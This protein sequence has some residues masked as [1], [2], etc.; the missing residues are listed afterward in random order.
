MAVF[1]MG[2]INFVQ[3]RSVRFVSHSDQWSAHRAEEKEVEVEII[4]FIPQEDLDHIIDI[5]KNDEFD[6]MDYL[7][8]GSYGTVYGYKDYAI[9]KIYDTDPHGS[10][11]AKVLK[12]ISHLDSIPTLYAIIDEHTLV[13]ERI[14]GKT[15]KDYS[16]DLKNP[17]KIKKDIINQ[18]E[19]ILISILKLGYSP[20][21]LHESNVMI[22]E[23]TGTL[24]V[25]D[26]GF[27]KKHGND[28]ANTYKS[29][30]GY[31]NAQ[32]WAGRVLRDYVDYAEMPM[33]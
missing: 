19:D 28:D 12:D 10:S 20:H 24:K 4:N 1:Q 18:W 16:Y 15:V 8:S 17:W 13:V 30:R 23:K 5:Y 27:F 2:S 6:E 9:K 32:S 11:D 33:I 26:V 3:Q 7:G 25:V 21:D 22:E 14:R 31:D 29:D